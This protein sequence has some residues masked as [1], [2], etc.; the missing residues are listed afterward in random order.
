MAGAIAARSRPSPPAPLLLAAF[1]LTETRAEQPITPLHLFASR[2]RSGAYAA[3][4]LVTGSMFST[5]FFL[6]QFLQGVRGYSPLQAGL[7]FLPMTAVMFAMG[8][9]V[10]RLTPRFGSSRLLIGRAAHRRG[11]HRL[12]EPPLGGHAL[13]PGHRDPAGAAR[14]RH[15]HGVHAADGGGHR[16]SRPG[17]AGAASGL[18]NVAQQLGGSLGLGILITV[19][20][21]ASRDAAQ[22]PLAGASAHAE[23]SHELAHAVAHLADGL[24]SPARPGPGG[25]ARGD[26]PPGRGRGTGGD[27]RLRTAKPLV[28]PPA[29]LGSDPAT[30]GLTPTRGV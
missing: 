19:F 12:A 22:H 14:H 23:A 9:A 5:F 16:G 4:V 6:T 30:R 28:T 20:A 10:P 21:S 15:R 1:G 18:L 17:D 25:G 7:A 8:R 24:G 3:R 26:A 2:Q 11:R 13:L 27:P 29:S